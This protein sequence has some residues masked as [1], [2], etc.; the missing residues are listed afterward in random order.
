MGALGKGTTSLVGSGGT[1]AA[2]MG[3][4]THTNI[5]LTDT[6]ITSRYE[7]ELQCNKISFR[8]PPYFHS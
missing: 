7:Q 2:T 3:D 4:T 6:D 1:M 5:R 8:T